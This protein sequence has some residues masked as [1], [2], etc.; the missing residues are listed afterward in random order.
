ML[1]K[2][3]MTRHPVMI[4]PGWSASEAQR[5]M[6]DNRLR[7][8]PVVEDGKRL[9]GLITRQRL[10]MKPDALGSLNVW[11]ISRYL[12]DLKVKQLMI[13]R[14][15]L[16]TIAEDRTVERAASVMS[17]HRVGCLPV[18]EEGGVVL[19]IVT[20]I[21]ISR[22]FQEMLGLPAEGVRV[23]VRMPNRPGEFGKLTRKLGENGWGVMGVGTFPSRK[24]PTSY[25][26]VVK[27]PGVS[28]DEVEEELSSIPDQSVV[29]IRASS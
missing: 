21:D 12:S 25:L 5:L 23:T 8:L 17:E 28:L 7:H 27:I 6:A 13:K 20:E 11:E 2:D 1:V 15:A 10:S 29:D 18:L 22:A 24:D 19:G 16:H 9:V 26:V 4:S 3:C 14:S